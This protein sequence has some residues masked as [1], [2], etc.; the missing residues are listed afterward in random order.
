MHR[1]VA[2]EAQSYPQI[3]SL[4]FETGPA[5]VKH[6]VGQCLERMVVD[7]ELDIPDIEY[8]S[9]LLPNMAFGAFQS[10]SRLGSTGLF[11]A[12]MS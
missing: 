4:F 7:G 3:A 12:C 1:V 5:A 11:R 6:A 10:I 2:G 8:A 9:W